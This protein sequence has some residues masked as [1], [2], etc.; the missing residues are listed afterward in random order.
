MF[1][2]ISLTPF[3]RI[4]PLLRS[5]SPPGLCSAFRL[6]GENHH[7]QSARKSWVKTL[8]VFMK[9]FIIEEPSTAASQPL[10]RWAP[11]PPNGQ[12]CQ[13][14]GLK[15]AKLYHLLSA[16]GL[17]GKH[18][19]VV[20]LRTP[21]AKRGQTLFHVGDMLLFLDTLAREQG[22]AGPAEHL[23]STPRPTPGQ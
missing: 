6:L 8:M 1:F 5:R 15:H 19:R 3:Q 17:T 21:G 12:T 18:V 20:N 16:D 7:A 10:D 11:I 9:T 23:N 13:F 4:I 2:A 22:G 14:T